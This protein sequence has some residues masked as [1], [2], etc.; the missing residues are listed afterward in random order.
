MSRLP[1]TLQ[2]AAM[3]AVLALL[4]PAPVGAG[5]LTDV[6]TEFEKA[7]SK[8][9]PA[10][11]I[12][13]P[14]GVKQ[15]QTTRPGSSSGVIISRKGL[16]LS[17]GDAGLWYEISGRGRDRKVTNHDS[18]KIEIRIPDLSG[19]GFRSYEAEVII[20][21]RKL[22]T[23]LIRITKPPS[24]LKHLSIGD[25]DQLQV[26]DFA[27][28]MG[29]SFGLA[30]EAP[31]TLTA[32]II[33]GMVPH[34][35]P[36]EGK[37]ATL[38][39]SA[40]VN[41][42]VNG[43]P[44]VDIE[45]RLVGV[46]SG[47]ETP[48]D[49][50]TQD[51]NRPFQ[52]LGRVIPI[53]R[54]KAF[55]AKIPEAGDIFDDASGDRARSRKAAVLE[56]VF[57][58]TA[59]RAYRGVVSI[60]IT[61]KD[62]KPYKH[63]LVAAR[64]RVGPLPRYSGPVSGILVNNQGEVITSIYNL[65]NT[66]G[67]VHGLPGNAPPEA[68][69]SHGLAQI[70]KITVHMPDGRAAEAEL[71]GRH[72]GLGVALLKLKAPEVKEGAEAS[73]DQ[74]EYAFKTL[75]PVDESFYEAGRMV[76]SIAN[77]FGKERSPD[78]LLTYGILSKQHAPDGADRWA[79]QWQTDCS[80]TDATA[81]GAIV[82]LRGRLVGMHHVW[83]PGRH[84]RNSGISFVVPWTQIEKVL[85]G[86]REGRVFSPPFVGVRWKPDP[87]AGLLVISVV[88]DGPAAKAGL[89][90]N[91]VVLTIDGKEIDGMESVPGLLRGKWSGDTV[92]FGVKRG[93]EELTLQVVLG[94]R[95]D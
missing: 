42:G 68:K 92:A 69:L 34:T 51:A 12:C 19:R 81:G 93:D 90:V 71:V 45:G 83:D 24:G 41:Q 35:D 50:K 27:F 1:R 32:G 67:I 53:R 31:P 78:P 89:K 3:L 87:E 77:P 8:V 11:V 94:S 38:F 9:T 36:T 88:A 59:R 47:P 37:H 4:C 76:L 66:L 18:D 46:I 70:T 55:Y 7:I 73:E 25:S 15:S 86:L 79:G 80:G 58:E 6:E 48:W 60:E 91:D 49:P 28:A 29:N 43:G 14:A 39:T 75:Q 64:G 54:L 26:G 62:N 61:R 82:D 63:V 17:D 74:R 2:A 30:S 44:L 57:H 13:V 22:D 52:F 10:T 23:T 72:D 16:I 40:A 33:S 21:E 85:P 20:R 56:T 65:G 95:T 5:P 84:G